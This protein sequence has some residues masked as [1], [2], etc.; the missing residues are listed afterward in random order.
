M[1]KIRAS[2]Y[3][4]EGEPPGEMQLP[5]VTLP[6]VFVII[7]HGCVILDIFT[8][9]PRSIIG[10]FFLYGKSKNDKIE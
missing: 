9:S 2:G 4:E 1:V 3:M 5:A 10:N 7:L 6:F 8:P